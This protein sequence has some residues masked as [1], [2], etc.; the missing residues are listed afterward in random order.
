MA[1]DEWSGRIL[2]VLRGVMYA[3]AIT[4][5]GMALLALAVV[6][7]GLNPGRL[8]LINQLLKAAS[9]LAGVVTAVGLGGEKGLITGSIVGILYIVVGY[10]F[11]C[12]IDGS[13][14]SAGVMA[15]EVAAGA[16]V[17]AC[18]GVVSANM[19]TGFRKRA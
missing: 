1:K 15:M 12:L 13:E 9:I 8:T 6:Y 2:R 19:R 14:A 7:L 18:A 16:A 17:G 11:Y 5:A 10:A 4:L 3:S